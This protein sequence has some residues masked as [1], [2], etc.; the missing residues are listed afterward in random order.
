MSQPFTPTP[1]NNRMPLR[2]ELF[3]LT[4]T[5]A[6]EPMAH[7]PSLSI[8]LAG[9]ILVGLVMPVER[10]RLIGGSAAVVVDHQM[11]G[12]PVADWALTMLAG[13]QASMS[14]QDTLR[15][16]A[17]DAYQR[18]SAGLVAGGLVTE[19]SRRRLFGRTAAYPPTDSAVIPRV[20]GR[21]RYVLQGIEA[22]D[23]QTDVLAGLVRALG[24]ESALYLDAI[25]EDI[26]PVMRQMLNRVA[27]EYPGVKEI[28]KAVEGL[29]GESAISVYG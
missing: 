21:L 29:I 4:H 15:L 2:G 5:E 27:T 11:T 3:V 13:H 8:G 20:R 14:V 28:V 25:G 12:D 7:R 22:A 10:V 16:L 23:P 9:A 18:T 17:V 19:T 26:R 24:L 1:P 6:G